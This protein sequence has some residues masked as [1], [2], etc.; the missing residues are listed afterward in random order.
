MG[1]D[2]DKIYPPHLKN[3]KIGTGGP[4]RGSFSNSEHFLRKGGAEKNGF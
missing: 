4:A 2:T 1:E 3:A